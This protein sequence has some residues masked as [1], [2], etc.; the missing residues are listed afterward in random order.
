MRPTRSLLASR[1]AYRATTRGGTLTRR[2]LAPPPAT[3]GPAS[4]RDGRGRPRLGA[5]PAVVAA[6]GGR[7]GREDRVAM[8]AG[9]AGP[10]A[11]RRPSHPTSPRVPGRAL[12]AAGRARRRPP[13]GP[14]PVAGAESWPP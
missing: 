13:S 7:A 12:P 1:R 2:P 5:R 10:V 4:V 3:T 9:P 11:C 14:P 8:P 6:R